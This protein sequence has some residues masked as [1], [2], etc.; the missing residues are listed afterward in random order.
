MGDIDRP[1][2]TDRES[3]A[4]TARKGLAAPTLSLRGITRESSSAFRSIV[5]AVDDA[6]RDAGFF[7]VVDHT[8]P[9]ASTA[10]AITASARFFELP[11]EV[12]E[13]SRARAH[14]TL[15]RGY[16]R[17][18]GESQAAATAVTP[19]STPGA[20]G[21][22]HA[23]SGPAATAARAASTG[24]GAGRGPAAAGGA[25]VPDL[26]ETYCLAPHGGPANTDRWS[27][28]DVWPDQDLWWFRAA[29]EPFRAA[30]DQLGR[31]LLRVCGAALRDDP[32]AFDEIFRRPLGGLRV[33]HYPSFEGPVKP[34]VWRA[35]PHTDYGFLTLV[36]VDG[37]PGLEIFRNGAWLPVDVPAGGF[38][39][40]V[41]DLL[42]ATSG[43]RWN[44]TWHRVVAPAG[45][46][47]Q[48]ARTSLSYFQFPDH[49][50]PV[51]GQCASA[52]AGTPGWTAGDYLAAKIG[53]LF[54]GGEAQT[55][56]ATGG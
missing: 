52:R 29:L 4:P 6:C 28:A 49:R 34:G 14:P 51:V 53:L 8:V 48:P 30:V 3:S 7:C 16:V 33:N 2:R 31:Q 1:R 10:A 50:A 40:N 25:R 20:A 39:V 11:Q 12:K 32:T 27:A 17:L 5:T 26:S 23:A 46:G 18:G 55:D 47:R 45:P 22:T 15:R 41:G 35:G 38:V 21:T 9:A 13:R 44:S 42:A 54:G 19:R 36:A 43:D 56:Q 37:Q 24:P